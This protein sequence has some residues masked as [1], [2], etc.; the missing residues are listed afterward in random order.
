MDALV[1]SVCDQR[2]R[3]GI[4]PG[5]LLAKKG[6]REIGISNCPSPL[7]LG[8]IELSDFGSFTLFQLTYFRSIIEF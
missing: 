8:Q 7:N 3:V 5:G 1:V 6:R 2:H 4:D